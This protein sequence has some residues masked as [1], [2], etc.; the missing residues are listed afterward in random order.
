[1]DEQATPPPTPTP[2]DQPT[3]DQEAPEAGRHRLGTSIVVPIAIV[4][5]VVA[6]IGAI[7][8]FA[9]EDQDKGLATLVASSV[10]PATL[11][12][13]LPFRYVAGHIVV[14][15]AFGDGSRTVPLILDSG[16]P[17][18]VSADLADVYA[19]E[20]AGSLV[21]AS[22]D[23]QVTTTD[24]VSLAS[25]RLGGAE[26][27]DVGAAR[28]FVEPGNPLYCVSGHGLVG[29]SL[30]KEAVWQID[31]GAGTVTIAESVD[32]L[33]HVDPGTSIE[34]TTVTPASPSPVIEVP[35]GDGTLS[36]LVDTGSNGWLT[37]NPNDLEGTGSSVAPT[38]P[39][40][41]TLGASSTGTFET[42]IAY[43]AA[44]LAFGDQT[45]PSVPI[46]TT[47]TLPEG[48]GNI[49]NE[50]LANYVVTV[51]WPEG[52]L[53]LDPV[54]PDPRPSVPSSAALSWSGGYVVGELVEGATGT[55]GLELSAPVVAI[56]GEDVRAATFDD[57]CVWSSRQPVGRLG[58]TIAGDEPTTV[59]AAPVE[60]FFEDLGAQFD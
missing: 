40:Y 56:D 15:A 46:A 29:A 34:F 32:G 14:D 45:L 19:G 35:A 17:T 23:G 38:A 60:D 22:I 57:Y 26:F 51:D 54:D 33:D 2:S 4:A 55:A 36:F 30:M 9:R 8:L 13:T 12:V 3:P 53:Y 39:A 58:L 47:T 7:V 31:Y 18:I 11:P 48:R 49:G 20:S 37:V 28:G 44:D 21:S 27:R 5:I 52:V 16:A 10:D 24:V 43:T 50:F 41:T 59:D 42:R 25:L 6:I 1:M